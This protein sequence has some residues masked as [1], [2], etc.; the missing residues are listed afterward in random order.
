M[1]ISSLPG[2][3]RASA[4]IR[5]DRQSNGSR[6]AVHRSAGGMEAAGRRRVGGRPL[7]LS[8]RRPV[9]HRYGGPCPGR[10][11]GRSLRSHLCGPGGTGQ[12]AVNADRGTVCSPGPPGRPAGGASP[13][14]GGPC[15]G[16]DRFDRHHHRDPPSGRR[17][18]RPV[19]LLLEAPEHRLG[20]VAPS[21]G[22][23]G[24]GRCRACRGGRPPRACRGGVVHHP[25]QL[26]A[27]QRGREDRPRPG[28][29]Q[30]LHHQAG[31][32]GSAGHPA[33]RGGHRRRRLPARGGQHRGFL[34]GR[35][36][37]GHGGLGGREHGQLHRFNRGGSGYLRRRS[38]DHDPGTYGTRRQGR[39]G[40]D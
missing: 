2:P 19:P 6:D 26:P 7:D 23:L 30:H 22:S 33:A 37:G 9:H 17:A 25:L 35:G 3:P 28:H 1:V 14:L 11:G 12:L 18:H 4:T 36:A 21:S 27:Y 31:T 40:D 29:G 34:G 38:G 39:P 13:R 8:D 10:W 24:A 20:R 5:P 15:P 32:P 16:R